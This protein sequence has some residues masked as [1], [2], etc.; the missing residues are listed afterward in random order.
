MGQEIGRSRFTEVD[1]RA[2][3]ARLKEE[4][5]LLGRWLRE[6]RVGGAGTTIGLELEAWLVDGC[7]RPAPCSDRFLER[8][9]QPRVENELALFNIEVNTETH[10]LAGAP[11]R[12]LHQELSARWS[13][14][15]VVAGGLGCAPLLIG[16]LPSLVEDDLCLAHMTPSPRYAALNEQVLALRNREPLVLDIAGSERY[17]TQRSDVMLEAATTSLQLHLQVPPDRIAAYFNAAVALSAPSVAVAANAPYLFGRRLWAESRIPLFEQA[18]ACTHVESQ[19]AG[20]LARVGFGS[21]YAR[22]GLYGFFVENRQHHPVLLPELL[23]T[24]PEELAHLRLHNG[25]IWRW[26]RPL[27]EVVDGRCQLRLEHRVMSAGPTPEDVLANAA[28]FYGAVADLAE[29][30]P[31]LPRRLPFQVAEQNFYAAA[32]YGLNAEVE[33]L[34]GW[35]GP[36]RELVLERLVPAA[37]RGL[38]RAGVAEAEARQALGVLQ[39]RVESGQNGAVWQQAWVER[40]GKDMP[41]LTCAY[42]ELAERGEPVHRWPV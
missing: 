19:G 28:F 11:F 7:G 35:Y 33:W 30:E 26:N 37:R 32:R 14:A 25:T 12:A 23:D 29:S 17:T 41:A 36:V 18:V 6:G 31:Q 8:I 15:Q 24:A 42:R 34:D 22:D 2:F 9:R 5:A 16:I 10:A 3:R 13:H 1:F 27:V 40:Y 39:A 4:T 21:G 20:A 38:A